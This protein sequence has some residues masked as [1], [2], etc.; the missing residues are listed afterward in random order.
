MKKYKTRRRTPEDRYNLN[1]RKQQQSLEEFAEH[2]FEWSEYLLMWYRCRKEEMP[3]DVYRA[4][5]FFQN[6]EYKNKQG[7]LTLLYQTHI[8]CHK[9]LP[10]ITK[11]NAF[12]ILVYEFRM[13]AKVLETGGF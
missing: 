9:E 13:F 12:D 3:D 2:E 1:V 6:R 5:A 11:E 8:Q 10:T 7:S 4:Y